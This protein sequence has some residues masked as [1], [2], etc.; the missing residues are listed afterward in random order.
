MSCLEVCR[1]YTSACWRSRS[2]A[3]CGRSAIR[4]IETMKIPC[5]WLS[6]SA[7]GASARSVGSSHSSVLEQER[8]TVG[9]S[10][11]SALESA[12]VLRLHSLGGHFKGENCHPLWRCF[13]SFPQWWAGACCTTCG[14]PPNH[15]MQPTPQPVIKFAYANLP[16]AWA[17]A[18]AG[19]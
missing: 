14:A 16:P 11:R 15:C 2:S 1:R 9:V 19:C 8:R 6:S 5:C 12:S 7:L 17:A 18:D 10:T 13:R 3:S 4:S